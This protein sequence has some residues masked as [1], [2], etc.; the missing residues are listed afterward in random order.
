VFYGLKITESMFVLM[1]SKGNTMKLQNVIYICLTTV[2]ASCLLLTGCSTVPVTGRSQLNLVSAGQEMELGLTSFD[3]LKKELPVSRDPA[4]NDL[5]QRV[6]KRVAAIATKDMPDAQWE[7]VVFDSK[8]A[9]AFCLPGGKV[10]VYT[11][12]LPIT[13]D[14]AGLATVIAHEVAHAVARHG[15]ERMSEA[16]VMQTGGQLLG[17]TL[18]SADAQ[19]Q[20]VALLAYGA[21][22][23]LGRELPHSRQQELEA[24]RIGLSYMA[25]AGYDP[26][27]AVEFWKRF[28][29]FTQQEG[30]GNASWLNR[31]L[32]THPVDEVRIQQ[33]QK[34]LPQAEREFAQ[35]R[36][37]R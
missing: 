9:N 2:A 33:I 16:M 8:E 23:K 3:Q 24:D 7:F 4:I 26:R 14:E 15:A 5:V 11:G 36:I 27:A 18:S 17:S 25:R 35:S 13:A 1:L 32:S 28:S 21:G 19:W 29:N 20:Q 34:Y 10:G 31:F 12:I 6:G 22:A 30:G 37:Q